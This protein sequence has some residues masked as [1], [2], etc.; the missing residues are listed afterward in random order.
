MAESVPVSTPTPT[1]TDT[2]ADGTPA[3]PALAPEPAPALAPADRVP[4]PTP[5]ERFAWYAGAVALTVILLAA[6]YRLDAADLAAPFYYDEDSLLILPMVKATLE[7][8]SHWR[9]ERMGYPGVMELHDFPVVDHLHFA[10]IWVLGR[11]VSNVVVVYNLYYLLTYPLTTLAAMVALRRLGLTLPAAAVGGLLYA[12]LPYHYMRGENHYFLSA[13]WLVPLSLLPLFALF[14]GELPFFRRDRG[15][16]AFRPWSR[17]A[18]G[19]VVLGAATA[20]AGA[21]YAFFACA[22]Y[23]FGGLYGWAV[24]RT[25]RAAASAGLLAGVVVAFGVLNHAPAIA[26]QAKWGRNPVTDR[27]PEEAEIY[28]MKIT[29]L[30]LP[31]NDHNLTALARVKSSYNSARRP[32]QNENERATLGVVGAA[33]LLGLLVVLVLP[34]RRGWPYDP[35]AAVVGFILLL[36]TVGGFGAIFNHLVSDQVR[37]YNRISVYL[38]FF[39]LFAVLWWLDGFLLTRTGRARRLR[40]P[41]LAAVALV[42][43]L[44]Q[45]PFSWFK[46][47]FVGKSLASEAE[48]FYKDARFFARVEAMMPE[49]ARVFNLPYMPFPEVEPL[50]RM[51]TYEPARGY[52][53]TRALVW[54]Y[55]AMKNRDADA[56]LQ[57]VANEATAY[58]RHDLF[59]LS[60]PHEFLRRVVVRGFDGLL[61]DTRG[62]PTVN[63]INQGHKLVLAIQEAARGLDPHKK[64]VLPGIVHEDGEQ[65]FL[66]LRPYRDALRAA[67]GPAEYDRQAQEERD[68]MTVTWLKGIHQ[69]GWPGDENRM[70]WGTRSGTAVVNNPTDR[71]RTVRI[72]MRLGTDF[73]GVFHV[74]ISGLIGDRI[75]VERPAV[76]PGKDVIPANLGVLKSYVVPVPPG[77]H[78]IRFDCVPPPTYMPIDTQYD[79][80]FIK[81]F[82][83]VEMKK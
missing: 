54:S 37:C 60:L 59:G 8:G 80:F 28:G 24:H 79:Y 34:G 26:Y 46:T 56:W 19:Q 20:S 21:Y 39:C 2:A 61:I 35:L 52:L 83:L 33:G 38:A 75:D 41:A 69:H 17:D 66:D 5:R 40:Y 72:D 71:T 7:R 32:V 51:F 23:A 12:F 4:P 48:R 13:Y 74:T 27:I 15:R 18:L 68:Q 3:L 29:H 11:V 9:N 78:K 49:G 43:L 44:D 70:R 55:G 6:G 42:G 81:N 57:E 25:W 47:Q 16:Y 31:I 73:R 62:F 63:H 65:V 10:L 50:H 64:L 45:T 82:S 67:L 22:L 1:E 14:K 53:H 76:P 30:V 77:R 58:D 36:A